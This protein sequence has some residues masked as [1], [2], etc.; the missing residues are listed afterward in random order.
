MVCI[1]RGYKH[2]GS[3]HQ[4]LINLGQNA[5]SSTSTLQTREMRGRKERNLINRK[6]QYPLVNVHCILGL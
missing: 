1:M 4:N 6:I 2:K 3:S 5:V